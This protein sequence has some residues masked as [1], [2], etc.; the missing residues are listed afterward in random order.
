VQR[1]ATNW[2]AQTA[3]VAVLSGTAPPEDLAALVARIG[4]RPVLLIRAANGHPDE[5]LNA[6]YAERI[7]SSATQWLAPGG[8]TLAFEADP[9]G[10]ERQV[11]GFLDEA[12]RP[13]PRA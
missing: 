8:H 1:W 5:R 6:V 4:P 2:L 7:G 12:L 11:I 10:Y 3:A 13:R 9:I